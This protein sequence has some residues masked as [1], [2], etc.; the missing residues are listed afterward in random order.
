MITTLS[1]IA[2]LELTVPCKLTRKFA[3]PLLRCRR[4][5][6]NAVAIRLLVKTHIGSL[7]PFV[8]LLGSR[9]WSLLAVTAGLL[10]LKMVC[11]FLG[12]VL[13]RL[14]SLGRERLVCSMSSVHLSFNLWAETEQCSADVL[15]AGP[16]FGSGRLGPRCLSVRPRHLVQIRHL[17]S[18]KLAYS[19]PYATWAGTGDRGPTAT[20]ECSLHSSSRRVHCTDPLMDLARGSSPLLVLVSG[21]LPAVLAGGVCLAE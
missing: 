19:G 21:C 18:G 5:T 14:V 12:W 4:Y 3:T 6:P 9:P 7:P 15:W 11:M 2:S 17:P 10:P 20:R 16:N 13:C 1:W 8:V